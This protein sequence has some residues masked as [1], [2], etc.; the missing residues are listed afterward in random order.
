MNRA[1]MFLAGLV[2]VLLVL[3]WWIWL[4]IE[5]QIAVTFWLL[6]GFLATIF[7]GA[8]G[9]IIKKSLEKREYTATSY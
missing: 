4:L 6:T 8:I 3:I 9:V 5:N 7:C 1:V 2:V